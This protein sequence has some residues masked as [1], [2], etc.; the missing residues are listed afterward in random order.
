MCSSEVASVIRHHTAARRRVGDATASVQI[1]TATNA[2][3][4]MRMRSRCGIRFGSRCRGREPGCGSRRRLAVRR[5][6]SEA[7]RHSNTVLCPAYSARNNF[8]FNCFHTKTQI[9]KENVQ[10]NTRIILPL[11]RSEGYTPIEKVEKSFI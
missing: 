6:T 4:Y 10:R 2:S 11:Q 3:V 5:W 9:S 8:R 7:R 1:H